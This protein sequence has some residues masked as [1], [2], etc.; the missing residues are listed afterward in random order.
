MCKYHFSSA[1]N[2]L[3]RTAAWRDED[4][5]EEYGFDDEL[6]EMECMDWEADYV[7]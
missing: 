6:D 7:R 1:V 5:F 3:D 2:E 4:L